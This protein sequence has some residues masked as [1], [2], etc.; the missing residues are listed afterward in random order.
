MIWKSAFPKQMPRLVLALAVVLLAGCA[1]APK[2]DPVRYFF[3]PL[4]REPHVEFLNVYYS[5]DDF[6][7]TDAQKTAEMLVGKPPLDFFEMPNSIASN[8]QG[9]V[10]VSEPLTSNIVVFDFIANKRSYL[11]EGENAGV[12]GKPHGLAVDSQGRLFAVDNES[13]KIVVFSPQGMPLFAFGGA[14][15]F[16]RPSYLAL[17]ERLGRV[18][19]SDGKTAKINVFDLAGNFLFSFGGAGFEPGRMFGPAGIAI[20]AD[21]KVYVAEQLNARIQYFD[22]DG[23]PLGSFGER[24]TQDFNMEGPRG[25][26]FDSDQNLHVL[27]ARQA[28]WKIYRPDGTLLLVLGASGKSTHPMGFTFP[29]AIWIDRNDRVYIVDSFN[30]RFTVWQYFNE[31]YLAKDPFGLGDKAGK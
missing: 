12:M 28:K 3:P 20:A 10:Y 14:Q 6:P 13:K 21:D 19:V 16:E 22:A 31:Q 1:S 17:N 5:Q 8:G 24:G 27:D 25:L 11:Y 18:Y 23:N 9:K 30:K 4:P 26:A 2:Q 15:Y 29:N 7:K